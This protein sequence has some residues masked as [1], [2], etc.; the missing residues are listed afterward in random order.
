MEEEAKLNREDHII[1]ATFYVHSDE[2]FFV[3]GASFIDTRQKYGE[4]LTG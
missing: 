2:I 4:T 3:N 1:A